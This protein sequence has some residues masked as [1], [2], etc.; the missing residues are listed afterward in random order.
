MVQWEITVDILKSLQMKQDWTSH[1]PSHQT[2]LGICTFLLPPLSL[3]QVFS[4]F[5]HLAYIDINLELN[6]IFFSLLLASLIQGAESWFNCIGEF[7]VM[8]FRLPPGSAKLPSGERS[9]LLWFL[10]PLAELT[11]K[12]SLSASFFSY[13]DFPI[14]LCF[15]LCFG[16]FLKEGLERGEAL[17]SNRVGY[18]I[19][20][21][22]HS[23]CV[24]SAGKA[25]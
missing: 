6:S 23:Y 15:N 4:N 25:R 16:N 9:L 11:P 13:Q 2:R 21:L 20:S 19:L 7:N 14:L 3:T 18:K 1:V 22:S 5:V 12:Q 17:A 24:F 10:T 8:K